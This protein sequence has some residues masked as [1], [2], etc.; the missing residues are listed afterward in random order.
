MLTE[1]NYKFIEKLLNQFDIKLQIA[2]GIANINHLKKL[3]DLG[4]TS[5]IV[6]KAIYTG[7]IDLSQATK[8][9]SNGD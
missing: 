8:I 1:P 7:E 9:Y 2:G 4:V 3:D 5:A 6:G